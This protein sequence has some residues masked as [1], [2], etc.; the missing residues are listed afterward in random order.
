MP[1]ARPDD[2]EQTRA[3]VA[4]RYA[5]LAWGIGRRKYAAPGLEVTRGPLPDAGSLQ[6]IRVTVTALNRR[7]RDAAQRAG[8][9]A[10]AGDL[11]DVAGTRARLGP[12]VTAW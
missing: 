6:R 8:V 9:A 7:T 2:R 5:S 10:L 11:H 1:P 12:A 3:A 4:A